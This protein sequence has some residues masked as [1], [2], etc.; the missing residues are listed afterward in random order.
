MKNKNNYQKLA[1]EWFRLAEDDFLFA[2]A[3]YKET[4]ISRSACFLSQQVA[5]KYLKGFLVCRGIEPLRIHLL[6]QLLDKIAEIDFSFKK[7]RDDC[8]LLDNYYNPA[9]YP[10]DMSLE[11]SPRQAQEALK[12]AERIRDFVLKKV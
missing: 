12:A 10:D 7:I 11:Y 4:K 1:Q 8:H 6:L 3:G 2:K 5:E 9:R